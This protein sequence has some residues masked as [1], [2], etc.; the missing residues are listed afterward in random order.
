[1]KKIFLLVIF[2]I[3]C[4]NTSKLVAQSKNGVYKTYYQNGK[5]K[6]DE[7]FKNGKR[8]GT[9]KYY[10]ENGKLLYEE[11][12]NNNGLKEGITNAFYENG[13]LESS[14][15]YRN[16]EMHG[17]FKE[18]HEDGKLKDEGK[19]E[20][21]QRKYYP[22]DTSQNTSNINLNTSESQ[23]SKSHETLFTTV[24]Q[25]PQFKGGEVEMSRFIANNLR[26]P[27]KARKTEIQGKVTVRFIVDE[28]G[29]VTNPQIVRG[30]D[31]SLD[32][33]ALRIIKLMPQ[34][35][36]GKQNGRNVPVYFTLPIV[37]RLSQ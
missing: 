1:M 37:F 5:V 13:Q 2:T 12:F 24:E 20:Y 27:I 10:A 3:I 18:F 22:I 11:N 19:Y 28:N 8:I 32:D 7:T 21:G 15:N 31:K 26:Y 4:V 16:G 9:C 33:E 6:S 29:N 30:V 36:A 34:W 35:V 14:Y 23:N 17:V 25:M